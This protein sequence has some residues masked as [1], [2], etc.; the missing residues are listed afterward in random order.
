MRD[1][2]KL[3]GATLALALIGLGANAQASP[4]VDKLAPAFELKDQAGKLHRLKDYRGKV[5]VLEWTN[6]GCPYVVRH[7]KKGTMAG[8]ASKVKG[9]VVWLAVNSSHFNK[10]KD[11]R[12]WK[13]EHKLS[14]ATLQD[15]SGKVG[16]LYG[17]RTTPHMF[18][19]DGKG[20][21]RYRGA[22]DDDPYGDKDKPRNL[23][24][25]AIRAVKKGDN[26]RPASTKPYGCSVKFRK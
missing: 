13:R 5:V 19:I 25:A 16:R 21:L 18:V 7:Y 24:A 8:L 9:K 20:V 15:P 2:D 4:A 26:P 22:I 3:I 14:Y 12:E 1:R 23:V 11:S 10:P 6:P 17:A